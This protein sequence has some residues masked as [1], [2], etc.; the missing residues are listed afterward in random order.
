MYLKFDMEFDRLE[1]SICT[2]N[3]IY[4]EGTGSHNNFTL[5]FKSGHG[6]RMQGIGRPSSFYQD[7]Q[8]I[9]SVVYYSQSVIKT[10]HISYQ[11]I[12]NFYFLVNI[13]NYYYYQKTINGPVGD[14]I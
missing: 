14:H 10:M 8:Y 6:C 1:A 3:A 12:L 4:E 11:S 13:R 5:L 2:K 7:V 9:M